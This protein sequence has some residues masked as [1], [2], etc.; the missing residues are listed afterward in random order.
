MMQTLFVAAQV[1]S[2][3]R[4]SRRYDVDLAIRFRALYEG[5]ASEWRTGTVLDLSSTGISL[6]SFRPLPENTPIEMVVD[7]PSRQNTSHPVRL[8]ASGEVVR[9]HGNRIAAR[10]TS[11]HLGIERPATFAAA[12]ASSLAV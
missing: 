6:R 1:E 3:R 9:S 10:I 11:S 7:W 5:T 12:A 2:R 4:R 8:R